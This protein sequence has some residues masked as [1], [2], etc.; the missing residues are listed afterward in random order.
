MYCNVLISVST[1]GEV[2]VSFT[3]DDGSEVL[4]YTYSDA[5]TPVVTQPIAPPLGGTGGGT[6]LTIVGTGFV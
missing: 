6:V 3:W 1:T 5:N 2:P 4:T